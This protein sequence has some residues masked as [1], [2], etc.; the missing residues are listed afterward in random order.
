MLDKKD[1]FASLGSDKKDT[2]LGQEPVNPKTGLT[3]EDKK[4]LFEGLTGSSLG[5][6]TIRGRVP[7]SY[8]RILGEEGYHPEFGFTAT[9][10]QLAEEQS[11]VGQFGNML[12]QMIVGEI[13]G[14]TIEG[15]GYLL[16]IQQYG[17]LVNGTE[18]EWGNWLS[19]VGK[20]LR[21]WTQE[22]SPIYVSP[23]APKF[24]PG[25]WSWWMSNMPS[26]GSTLSLLIPAT[27]AVKGISLLGKALNIG[28]KIGRTAGWMATGIGRALVSRHM[29]NLM[30]ASGV[31]E[32]SYQIAKQELIK[33]YADQINQE[34]SQSALKNPFATEEEKL[35][36]AEV[37]N[38]KWE[39]IINEQAKIHASKAAANTYKKQWVTVMQDI[40]QYLLFG[41]PPG[42]GGVVGK[43]TKAAKTTNL[44]GKVARAMGMDVTK[45]FANKARSVAFDM[46]GEG[47]EEAYQ[48]II[49]EQ[50]KALMRKAFDPDVKHSFLDI[51]KE[52]YD[53]GEL[54][55]SAVFGALGAGAMQAVGRGANKLFMGKA[56]KRKIENIRSWSPAMA[57]AYQEYS[58]ALASDDPI[59]QRQAYN[60]F[61]AINAIKADLSGN[62]DNFVEFIEQMADNPDDATLANFNVQKE[63]ISFLSE[64]PELKDTIKSDMNRIDKLLRTYTK[65]VD[66]NDKISA[67]DK[68]KA[69]AALTHNRF[70]KEKTS[71]ELNSINDEISQI[72]SDLPGFVN[73]T[74]EVNEQ[75][76][77]LIYSDTGRAIKQLEYYK[78][79][80]EDTIA[81]RQAYMDA[82]DDTMGEV[83][84]AQSK[85]AISVAKNRLQRAKGD[86]KELRQKYTKEERKNDK[87][88]LLDEPT[89]KEYFS[90]KKKK[91]WTELAL[92]QLDAEKKYI[93]SGKPFATSKDKEDTAGEDE[94]TRKEDSPNIDDTVE[95]V[96]KDG[97]TVRGKIDDIL[98]ED[99]SATN[100]MYV[101]RLLDEEGK[102]TD[103]TIVLDPEEIQDHFKDSTALEDSIDDIS[104]PL[105]TEEEKWFEIFSEDEE[106]GSEGSD[107]INGLSYTHFDKAKNLEIRNEAL[108]K[109]LRDKNR[110]WSKAKAYYYIDVNSESFDKIY[111]ELEDILTDAQKAVIKK[112]KKIQQENSDKKLTK[113]EIGAL[114]IVSYPLTKEEYSVENKIKKG[115]DLTKEEEVISNRI[116][117]KR[118][119]YNSLLDRIPIFVKIVQGDEVFDGGMYLHATGHDRMHVPNSTKK[120]G[121]AAIDQ[122]KEEKKSIARSNR[123]AIFWAYLKGEEPY[124]TGLKIGRGSLKTIDKSL[125]KSKR[126]RNLAKVLKK[127]FNDCKLLIAN[128]TLSKGTT[129]ITLYSGPV[130]SGGKESKFGRGY[131]SA[132]GVYIRD[133]EETLNGEPYAIHT[134][135]RN[136]S[137]EHAL[138]VLEAFRQQ[139]YGV[140]KPKGKDIY[141]TR[142]LKPFVFSESSLIDED[143][144][145]GLTTG[146]VLELLTY[147]GRHRTDPTD[148]RFNAKGKDPKLLKALENKTLYLDIGDRALKVFGGKPTVAL[149]YGKDKKMINLLNYSDV[150]EKKDDFIKWATKNLVYPVHLENRALHLEL[151]KN[152]LDG[153]TFRIGKKDPI[154]RKRGDR[155][156]GFVVRNNLITADF[157][158]L[159]DGNL[160]RA[161]FVDLNITDGKGN[162]RIFTKDNKPVQPV[163]PEQ[164]K[165]KSKAEVESEK[166]K[167]EAEVE[168]KNPFNTRRARR[169]TVFRENIPSKLTD[170]ETIVLVENISRHLEELITT[171]KSTPYTPSE[172]VDKLLKDTET[173]DAIVFG[174]RRG[175]LNKPIKEYI[176]MRVAGVITRTLIDEY[177][178]GETLTDGAKGS[179][180]EEA[181]APKVVPNV[182]E[183]YKDEDEVVKPAKVKK[184]VEQVAEEDIET[185][186]DV[187]ID[188]LNSVFEDLDNNDDLFKPRQVR[189]ELK[190]YTEQDLEK[191]L[192][193]VLK[194]I[195]RDVNDIKLIKR[196]VDLTGNGKLDWAAYSHDAIVLYE[197]AEEG[198]IYHETF[199]RVS[200]GYLKPIER[201][202]LYSLAKEFYKLKED[203]TD[204]EIEERL[205]E[206][207]RTYVLLQEENAPR[208]IM[209]I[210]KDILNFI[211]AFFVR[212]N[213]M[214]KNELD[215]FFESIY[216]GDYRFS[217]KLE[218]NRIKNGKKYARAIKDKE[219][220]TIVS[221][222]SLKN[223][224]KT[225]AAKLLAVNNVTDLN[226]VVAIDPNKLINYL[227]RQIKIFSVLETKEGIPEIQKQRATKVKALFVEILGDN[228]EG[229]AENFPIFHEYINAYLKDLGVRKTKE[230]DT[231]DENEEVVGKV[232]MDNTLKSYEVSVLDRSMASVKFLVG[233]LYEVADIEREVQEDG[234]VKIIPIKAIDETTGLTKFVDLH[235]VW[236]RALNDLHIYSTIEEMIDEMRAFAEKEN[237][238]YYYDLA[239]KLEKRKDGK[240]EQIRNQ[241]LSTFRKHKSL[242]IE[243]G[244]KKPRGGFSYNFVIRESSSKQLAREV[245]LMWNECFYLDPSIVSTGMDGNKYLNREFFHKL[246]ADFTNL[247]SDYEEKLDTNKVDAKVISDTYDKLSELFDRIHVGV[248][249][250]TLQTLADTFDKKTEEERVG[251]LISF[252]EK[253]FVGEFARKA[254]EEE[255]VEK[256][257]RSFINDRVFYSGRENTEQSLSEAYAKAHPEKFSDMVLGAENSRYYTFSQH[258]LITENVLKYKTDPDFIRGKK[259][260]FYNHHSIGLQHLLE[261][262]ENRRNFDIVTFN[263]M[264]NER[265][266]DKGS[267]FNKLSVIETYLIKFAA[268]ENG[269][270][271]MPVQANRSKYYFMKG[272]PVLNFNEVVTNITEDGY[273]TFSDTTLERFYGYFLDEKERIE[274]IKK[275]E[276]EYKAADE[277]GKA[278]IRSRMILNYHHDGSFDFKTGNARN[279]IHFKVFN[280]KN[281][282]K[283]SKKEIKNLINDDLNARLK[284]EIDYLVGIDVILNEGEG[285]ISNLLLQENKL[286]DIED[287]LSETSKELGSDLES[288]A[289]KVRIAEYLVNHMSSILESEKMFFA[290]PAMFKKDKGSKFDVADDVY[291][292]WFGPG[293]TGEKFAEQTDSM[294]DT[295]Y[296]VVTLN[297]Q[298]FKS[299]YYDRLFAKHVELNKQ[300]FGEDKQD[301]AEKAAQIALKAYEKVDATDGAMLI[302]PEFYRSLM[303]RL[304]A[305]SN[306]NQKAFELLQSN[307]KLTPEEEV[308]ARNIVLQPIKTVYVGSQNNNGVDHFIYD[309]MAMF[310]IFRQVVT[311]K[312]MKMLLDR[313]EAV[314]E[315]KGLDK[316]HAF[317]F[318][319][320][321]K[322]GN[323]RGIDFYLDP[324]NRKQVNVD[325][326][327]NAV[328]TPQMYENL[329]YQLV[330]DVHDVVEQNVASQVAKVAM[331]NIQKDATYGDKTGRELI[332]DFVK[333]ISELSNIGTEKVKAD[334]NIENGRISDKRLVATLL[335]AATSANKSEDLINALRYDE[336]RNEIY[337]SIDAMTNRAWVYSRLMPMIS[338]KTIDLTFPGNQLIQVPD[339]GQGVG[340]DE[341]LGFSYMDEKN[342]FIR[343]ESK[344][345][346]RLLRDIIPNYAK[347]THEQRKAFIKKNDITLIAYRV[348]VQGQNSIVVMKIA[349]LLPEQSGD[350]I[351]VPLEFTALTGSDFDIDKLFVMR[352]YYK[353]NKKGEAV[354]VKFSTSDSSEAVKSRYIAKINELYNIHKFNEVVI[355]KSIREKVE[356]FK[357]VEHSAR[358]EKSKIYNDGSYNELKPL[359]DELK[360]LKSKYQL[361]PEQD[362]E[363]IMDVIYDIQER[364]AI[365]EEKRTDVETG[366]IN[367][368]ILAVEDVKFQTIKD[369]LV[370]AGLISGDIE[371]FAKLPIEQQN[372][373]KALKNR[374]FDIYTTILTDEKQYLNISTPLGNLVKLL[375]ETA[376]KYETLAKKDKNKG[377]ESLETLTPKYQSETRFK[378]ISSDMGIGPAALTNVHHVLTQLTEIQLKTRNNYGWNE[379]GRLDLSREVGEDG[380][381]ILDWTSTQIDAFVDAVKNPFIMKL[382]VNDATQSVVNLLLRAGLGLT[383]FSF[384]S[385]PILKHYAFEYFNA[386]GS[387]NRYSSGNIEKLV[388]DNIMAIWAEKVNPDVSAEDLFNEDENRIDLPAILNQ[389]QLEEDIDANKQNNS[390]FY[391]RQ[392][393]VL[394]HFISI[395]QD[396]KALNA[397]VLATRVDTKDY[398][399][400]PIE[401]RQFLYN[402]Q[403]LENKNK[404]VNL[405]KLISSDG[406]VVDGGIH[407]SALLKNS[408]LLGLELMGDKSMFA[409]TGFA[410]TIR[411]IYDS[412][413]GGKSS[414]ILKELSEELYTY[415]IS[416][417]FI[418]AEDGLKMTQKQL[419]RLFFGLHPTDEGKDLSNDLIPD[420]VF[421]M[422]NKA[423]SKN[424]KYYAEL[425]N[426]KFIQ[427]LTIDVDPEGVVKTFIR[428]PFHS[429]NEKWSTDDLIEDFNKLFTH[430]AKE[431]RDLARVLYIYSFYSTGFRRTMFGYNTFIPNEIN[432]AIRLQNG[433]IVSFD[434]HVKK[435]VEFLNSEEG[436]TSM[437]S[438]AKR[439]VFKNNW[440]N[441]EIVKVVPITAIE[442][443]FT[444]GDKGAQYAFELS[445]KKLT[446]FK[447]G[448]NADGQS[449]FAP[450]IKMELFGEKNVL[451]EYVGYNQE[452]KNPIYVI[453]PRKGYRFRGKVLNEYNIGKKMGNSI[454]LSNDPF[455]LQRNFLAEKDEELEKGKLQYLT[456]EQA[457]EKLR[458]IDNF[459]HVPMEAQLIVRKKEENPYLIDYRG[460]IDVQTEGDETMEDPNAIP[461]KK[462]ISGFQS[463]MDEELLSLAKEFN[464]ETG[465]TTTRDYGQEGNNKV[466]SKAQQFGVEAVTEK[467]E[468]AF[469]EAYPYRN[470]PKSLYYLPRTELNVINSDATVYF[471]ADINATD[472]G[473]PA[474][475][476]AA[477]RH[478]KPFFMYTPE[479]QTWERKE[480][481]IGFSSS[482]ELQRLL[483]KYKVR[484]LNVAGSRLSKLSPEQLREFKR[485]F[486]ETIGAEPDTTTDTTQLS[487]SFTTT[488]D[489][490]EFRTE[491]L[492][493]RNHP[494]TIYVDGSDIK[495]TGQIGYG[496]YANFIGVDYTMSGISD[497]K[498]FADFYNISETDI[499]NAISNPTM[500]LLGTVKVLEQFS[501]TGEHLLIRQD[502]D[503]VQKW[504]KGEWKQKKLWIKDLV[505]KARE[506]IAA[507][508][509]HGGSVRFEWIPGHVGIPGNEKADTL[510][511]SRKEHNNISK[512]VKMSPTIRA[513]TGSIQT[514]FEFSEKDIEKG[515]ETKEKCNE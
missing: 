356:T 185:I 234:T 366:G 292:R 111:D 72:E 45:L 230:V 445:S 447:V 17:D 217:K 142:F 438:S 505:Q 411:D 386:S 353:V 144:V 194:M 483:R 93:E 228:E 212:P 102:L 384:V 90:A 297:T 307:K 80:L 288:P 256:I 149:V 218:E 163:V 320:A 105:T 472:G 160:Y 347:L 23:T 145:E 91:A 155:Y 368:I 376:D 352:K 150:L 277:D 459:V 323:V 418:D 410:K 318:D 183:E 397:L 159:A 369:L 20:D 113:K 18:Q 458:N 417:F 88:I 343:M 167:K 259:S 398:G 291:K 115:E 247:S 462:I 446:R 134:N 393:N 426:N 199:H 236:S 158:R 317:K 264:R 92:D 370:K 65:E 198:T 378:F 494:I 118:R 355:P 293:S 348:P 452:T 336:E 211:R 248:D 396:A 203:A 490:P 172:I 331:G 349:D 63:H 5:V 511:K 58:A 287:Y 123:S 166:A 82:H 177:K 137:E 270:M 169:V 120:K 309:K 316:I 500:E 448:L 76:E 147:H 110:D 86:L 243:M 132:G 6:T 59:K 74:D 251:S 191:E 26:I 481:G 81:K 514:S 38:T 501:K 330:T 174:D 258:N 66:K 400:N 94:K 280:G 273:V 109:A 129:G 346:E 263:L 403:T 229:V 387:I 382:N 345:S 274:E 461:T 170:Q 108:D 484:T 304:G 182:V 301:H 180:T 449:L 512:L 321:T 310:P 381:K 119:A 364:I 506:H 36:A 252:V 224:T 55:T 502:Y 133:E 424:S 116:H 112:L 97:Q 326:L 373:E 75:G 419:Y 278:E 28:Q 476:G 351:H 413:P 2:P 485:V 269:F 152:F 98:L 432:K 456:V 339:Y 441:D 463:G 468:E 276:K 342:E 392:L 157:E 41:M 344:V 200:L 325:G 300:I 299:K 153:R 240:N 250:A 210:L 3:E 255:A 427:F 207:F 271:P 379:K 32:E 359:Y 439:E 222:D 165:I 434:R 121:Q 358:L 67:E 354:P 238:Y 43:A 257:P 474:T 100:P 333:T 89:L 178:Y 181:V 48:F 12:N 106:I 286:M 179:P 128:G 275:L 492:S 124:T 254:E 491:S 308:I 436:N 282:S 319:S 138:I 205:A 473:L 46:L 497:K 232:R 122:Y 73:S 52:N 442:D 289:L 437:L 216:R 480:W 495:G 313:M 267:S 360:I 19:D 406:E 450:Y 510:A 327:K 7:K 209:K 71:K 61:I 422:L 15:I 332:Q 509:S 296:N 69:A 188:D 70:L 279:F 130:T 312:H 305:W 189:K 284:D 341:E 13:I 173:Y 233:T 260:R 202:R 253:V 114:T 96:N 241:F 164:E 482:N 371:V 405:E 469:K 39:K 507:I 125:P 372:T 265:I 262:E 57:Q 87:Q 35:A 64:N 221:R 56:D 362:K 193:R 496:A 196:L 460:G 467:Q 391:I 21:T 1:I 375:E 68:L 294:M 101:V 498:A 489:I 107:A 295:T 83:E 49:N 435:I 127:K 104:S 431:I 31:H 499:T 455:Y 385:Q 440:Q 42:L 444:Y 195:G 399:S 249:V 161:P 24:N 306:E 425:S 414:R 350:V 324:E 513:T 175:E 246:N 54:W 135:K 143:A 488:S 16:D 315:F 141:E 401:L 213:G 340:V 515:K 215:A 363:S 226:N 466:K 9:Q 197:A 77:N 420:S 268:L 47:G 136:M 377:L 84:K 40:P 148:P 402:I 25:S 451:L 79:S 239:N 487:I 428:T 176:K 380:R 337:L 407:L 412:I 383:T 190:N 186:E 290:D 395:N 475:L 99:E 464:Y 140:R 231:F 503:G 361:A 283:L 227:R 508:E 225:L 62:A 37:I 338:E 285:N 298:T 457:V 471:S 409:T 60:S 85:L 139:A 11:W 156:N 479:G 151:N 329:R 10:Q 261:S 245:V 30:E 219:F 131:K 168:Y 154:E 357:K 187:S 281:L 394:R 27:G 404:F 95:Y 78:Q 44:S 184:E 171:D 53:D 433:K 390:A 477:Q 493:T 235:E 303:M 416:G 465:G 237:R 29:E 311:N 214:T 478:S 423:R 454:L 322:V 266:R 117:K 421:N 146:Q 453:V 389:T 4:K 50:S 162:Q 367:D 415:F 314:G 206:E 51:I 33:Q 486:K 22:V 208:G 470:D 14:G 429:F 408:V 244:F 374:L 388:A 204:D 443:S 430:E 272:L 365:V 335:R 302:S 126:Q 8:E 504:I 328:I 334:F 34:L 192:K 242:F 201:K 220:D 223:I 103:Q